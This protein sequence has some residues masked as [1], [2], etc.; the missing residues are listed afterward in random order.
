VKR[1]FVLGLVCLLVLA[2]VVFMPASARP[3]ASDLSLPLAYI[4]HPCVTLS[5]DDPGS[6]PARVLCLPPTGL[7]SGQPATISVPVPWVDSKAPELSL[8]AIPTFF[9]V[10]WAPDSFGYLDSPPVTIS[11]PAG[12]PTD[13][14]V[15]VRFQLRLR[16]FQAPAAT[17]GLGNVALDSP[18]ASLHLY[19]STEEDGGDVARADS[20]ACQP[21]L[22]PRQ[23]SLLTVE[24]DQ[25]GWNLSS[26]P[27]GAIRS[28]L[29]PTGPHRPPDSS[30]PDPRYPDWSSSPGLK[31]PSVYAAWSAFASISGGGS[32]SGSPAYRVSATTYATVEARPIWSEHKEKH[33]T[34]EIRCSWDYWDDYDF[35]DWSVIPPFCKRFTVTSWGTFCTPASGNCPYGK[36]SDWWHP[37]GMVQAHTLR[38]P[39]GR[40]GTTYD[41]VV[42]QSQPLLFAP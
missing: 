29:E 11:Y 24:G 23:N 19:S 3:S 13:R 14:L 4:N 6:R 22:G 17:V 21:G 42:A 5:V 30:S 7:L 35:I 33:V 37:V 41:F 26:A 18:E 34:T 25:G 8:V 16:P 12:N 40:Y 31:D 39:E 1:R 27:C 32:A 38:W 9:N 15:D 36:P 10:T 28:L 2:A 20:R